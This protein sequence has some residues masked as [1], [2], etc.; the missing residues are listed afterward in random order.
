MRENKLLRWLRWQFAKYLRPR[1]FIN[2]RMHVTWLVQLDRNSIIIL[3]LRNFA[4]K[5]TLW[6]ENEISIANRRCNNLVRR[7]THTHRHILMIFFN[8]PNRWNNVQLFQTWARK[9]IHT[10]VSCSMFSKLV[11]TLQFHCFSMDLKIFLFIV[12]L[13]VLHLPYQSH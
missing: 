2:I 8:S 13:A 3:L 7:T 9:W 10:R 4:M 11:R 12:L 6:C 5:S 1:I